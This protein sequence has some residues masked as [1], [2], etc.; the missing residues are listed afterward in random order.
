MIRCGASHP[1][2][3][4]L[5]MIFLIVLGVS[6]LPGMKRETF[7]DFKPQ[8]IE[9]RAVYPGASSGDIEDA[10]CR[11]IED[12]VDGIAALAEI[13][14]QALEG[15]AV[16]VARMAEGENLSRFLGDVKT[17]VEAIDDFPDLV[18]KPTIQ[19]L[20]MVD[21]VVAIAVSRPMNEQGAGF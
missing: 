16:T 15:I 8:E 10:I 6:A 20:G 19:E 1:T 9:I 2:A 4:N 3:A 13:R 14:C 17:Q 7:P 12:A 21:N 18:E 5:L 11:R